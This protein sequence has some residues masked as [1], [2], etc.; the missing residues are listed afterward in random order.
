M[1]EL[2]LPPE[3]KYLSKDQFRQICHI[4][5]RTATRLIENG[6]VPAIDTHMKT[7]RYIIAREDVE[8]YLEEREKFPEKYGYVYRTYG[9]TC[10]YCRKCASKMRKLAKEIWKNEPDLL[11]VQE[12]SKLIGY[13]K[14]TIYRWQIRYGIRG[15]V[16]NGKLFI[17]KKILLDFIASVKFHAIERKS[18]FHYELVRRAYYE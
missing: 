3:Q 12:V 15:V 13:R 17:P 16:A 9:E 6:L 7:S 4:G 18:E 10:G 11:D 8:K 2:N 5:S 14:E 1:C